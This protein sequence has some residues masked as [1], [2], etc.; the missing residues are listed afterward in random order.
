MTQQ[1]AL[2]KVVTVGLITN[3]ILSILKVT[4]GILGSATS[5]VTDGFNSISDVL[6]SKVML[7][8]FLFA[9]QKP[10]HDHHYGHEKYEGLAYFVLGFVFLGTALLFAYESINSL[11]R[12]TYFTR[13]SPHISTIIV[14]LVSIMMKFGLFR[15]YKK[16]GAILKRPLIEADAKNHLIDVFATSVALI[17][18][19]ASRMGMPI[20]DDLASLIIALLIFK[21]G[22]SILVEAISFLTDQA[23]DQ[24]EVNAIKDVINAMNEVLSIDDL[25][26]RKH[27][28]Q[29]YVDVEIGVTATLSLKDAHDIAERV[30][31][32]VEETFPDVLHCMVHVNPKKQN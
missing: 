16:Q 5:L 29:R 9:T 19:F 13:L 6:V 4:F 12:G 7:I 22:Y 32:K 11:I 21:M 23:P 28:T 24:K 26:V 27:M 1:R 31:L 20:F 25:K 17:G 18:I 15:Y 2:I 14:S 3:L 10:D 8:I 30:H